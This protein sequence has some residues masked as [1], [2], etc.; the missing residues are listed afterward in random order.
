MQEAEM[1]PAATPTS[2]GRCRC[3]RLPPPSWSTRPWRGCFLVPRL[4][5]H[6]TTGAKP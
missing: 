5:L 6:M 4:L 1:T 2:H 3:I